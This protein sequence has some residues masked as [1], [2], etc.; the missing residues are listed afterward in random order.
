MH[1]PSSGSIPSLS[2][3][4]C[5]IVSMS[6]HAHVASYSLNIHETPMPCHRADSDPLTQAYYPA[7]QLVC[8]TSILL[9]PAYGAGLNYQHPP[10]PLYSQHPVCAYNVQYRYGLSNRHPHKSHPLQAYIRYLRC[11]VRVQ[12]SKATHVYM[13]DVPLGTLVTSS[14]LVLIIDPTVR[15]T[16]PWSI[17]TSNQVLPTL[18]SFQH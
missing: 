7:L 15:S 13:V 1:H 5:H 9:M 11:G 2:T 18:D 17:D 3:G 12:S 10:M 6:W 8:D 16:H 4:L 14:L